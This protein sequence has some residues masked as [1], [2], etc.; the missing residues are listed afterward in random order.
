MGGGGGLSQFLSPCAAGGLRAPCL[1][2]CVRARER[3][4]RRAGAVG[5][6]RGPGK[7]E[8]VEGEQ[9]LPRGVA[10]AEHALHL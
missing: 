4:A 3:S 7:G 10:V 2:R 8:E 6:E 1:P 5:A 9:V